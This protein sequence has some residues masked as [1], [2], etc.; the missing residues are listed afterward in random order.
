MRFL[1]MKQFF[2]VFIALGLCGLR[3]VRADESVQAAQSRLK[4]DGFYFGEA[5]GV[6]N[7]ATGA[8]V[9]RYQIRNGLAISGKL[10]SQTIQALGLAKAKPNALRRAPGWRVRPL[11][12]WR[13][14]TRR[15]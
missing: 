5:N 4:E 11:R 14:T 9:A 8:A 6:Y 1:L 12:G 7:D 10:D 13:K 2:L 15:M 3:A